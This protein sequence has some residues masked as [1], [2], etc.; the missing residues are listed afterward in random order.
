MSNLLSHATPDRFRKSVCVVQGQTANM[1]VM[2][3]EVVHGPKAWKA[4]VQVRGV[5][6]D[7][8]A[9]WGGTRRRVPIPHVSSLHLV[10]DLVN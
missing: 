8:A 4:A 7:V 6:A 5:P 3:C 10:L 1:Q 9:S 2:L